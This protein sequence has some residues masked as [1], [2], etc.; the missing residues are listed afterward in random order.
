MIS[1][2]AMVTRDELYKAVGEFAVTFSHLEHNVL[3][4]L[5]VLAGGAVFL[6]PI[7]LD[8]LSL[9]RVLGYMQ[10]YIKARL[11]DN[12]EL[13]ERAR[14]LVKEVDQ[15]RV[16]RNLII[17]GRWATDDRM[18]EGGRVTCYE[19]KLRYD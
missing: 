15:A 3:R 2:P 1:W 16:D 6:G 17:H 7:L 18:L 14:K 9:S 5:D 10:T 4:I 19:F 11:R 8:D 12:S 13:H